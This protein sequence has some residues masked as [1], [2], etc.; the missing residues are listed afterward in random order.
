[1]KIKELRIQISADYMIH[2]TAKTT[3]EGK[4]PIVLTNIHI[5]DEDVDWLKIL[6]QHCGCVW[7]IRDY[8]ED[9]WSK[10]LEINKDNVGIRYFGNDSKTFRTHLPVFG[11]HQYGYP[12]DSKKPDYRDIRV[13]I[14]DTN[15]EKLEYTI[16]IEIGILHTSDAIG[17]LQI[18]FW[19][20]EYQCNPRYQELVETLEQENSYMVKVAN[21]VKDFFESIP[22]KVKETEDDDEYEW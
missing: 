12:G 13:R 8:G 4:T 20:D 21:G 14:P 1:M 18:V 5:I 15:S 16:D 3:G 6:N 9:N 22:G 7:C 2:K 11:Y 10:T 19:V 17:R